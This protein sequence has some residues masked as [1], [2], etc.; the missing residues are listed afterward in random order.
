[1]RRN[2]QY[3]FREFYIWE[4]ASAILEAQGVNSDPL[5]SPTDP[6]VPSYDQKTGKKKVM[7]V[8]VPVVTVVVV[9]LVVQ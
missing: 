1:M 3:S 4:V 2:F 7:V 9:V 5:L 6:T 8:V